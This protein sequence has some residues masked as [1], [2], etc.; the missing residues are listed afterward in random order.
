MQKFNILDVYFYNDKRSNEN[1]F[2]SAYMRRNLKA[3]LEI[4]DLRYITSPIDENIKLIQYT[5][6]N[7]FNKFNFFKNKKFLKAITLFYSEYDL[8]GK[9]LKRVKEDGEI[10]YKIKEADKKTLNQFDLIFV[11]SL[12][13]K[14]LAIKE[15][16]DTKI[17]VLPP[18]IKLSRFEL[19][20]RETSKLIYIYFHLT[21]ET[22]FF[23]TI[24]DYTDVEAAD[25][26]IELANC[27]KDYKFIIIAHG[28]K[29]KDSKK[30][31]KKFKKHASNIIVSDFLENDTYCSIVYNAKAYFSL[32]SS[33]GGSLETIEA[34]SLGKP[35]LALKSSGF[36]DIL[37]DKETAYVYNDFASFI[38]GFNLFLA[39]GLPNLKD[40]EIE[41]SKNF[42]IKKVGQVLIKAYLEMLDE[43]KKDD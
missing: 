33:Y 36:E 12:K 32:N 17:K 6:F 40:K 4:N 18:L 25:R 19:E 20:N 27:F 39:G 13:A 11:P 15:G 23:Y 42:A 5:D 2:E 10:K 34:Y 24:L 35:V 38:D 26:I 28:F 9:A 14:E 8:Y 41:F 43:V 7:D 16:L 37:I 1:F 22:E 3:A 31:A 21:E 29:N 30:I